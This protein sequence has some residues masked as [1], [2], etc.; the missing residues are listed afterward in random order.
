MSAISANSNRCTHI[1]ARGRRCRTTLEPK[2]RISLYGSSP[3]S[4]R[5]HRSLPSQSLLNSI[6]ADARRF[7]PH[8]QHDDI[9]LVIAKSSPLSV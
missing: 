7:S 4:L 9:T 1:N 6:V 2:S 5:R 3:P 8:E